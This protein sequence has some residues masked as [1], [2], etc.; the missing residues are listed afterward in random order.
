MKKLKI[1][2]IIIILSFSFFLLSYYKRRSY[3]VSYKKGKYDIN[4]K[5]L[6]EDKNY[7]I[8]VTDNK[9]EYLFI[10]T[11]KYHKSRKLVKNIK[12]YK[13]DDETCI[14]IRFNKNK[15][16]PSC[17]K[18]NE[19][20]SYHLISDKMMKKI[21]LKKYQNT[22]KTNKFSYKN[23]DVNT[24]NDKKILIWNYH[25]FYYLDNKKK[26]DINIIKNDVYKPSFV[27]QIDNYLVIPNFDQ[28]YEY[29]ELKVLNTK[30][31]DI[32]TLELNENISNDSYVLGTNEDSVFVF[33]RKYH[34]EVEIVPYKLIYRI[35]DPFIYVN[36][37]I[38][39]K[40]DSYLAN[41]NAKFV[42]NTTYSYKLENDKLYQLN[43][44]NDDKKLITNKSVKEIVKE[45]NEEIYYI[46]DDKLYVYSDKYGEVL[47]LE[48]FELEFNYKNIIY[49]FN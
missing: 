49:I 48:Y 15:V 8:K 18:N 3:E 39:P 23:I 45:D 28:G 16:I 9:D 4:E 42:Y 27:G 12:K 31:I 25:G 43:K 22:I 1:M 41:S 2:I 7:V 32:S 33:D 46:S 44:Y 36:G 26:D 24:L 38:V 13:I 11:D 6:K 37:D 5:Y 19:N 21:G 35:V 14:E 34:R 29:K 40:S 47:M 17:K 30:K 20:I 10:I